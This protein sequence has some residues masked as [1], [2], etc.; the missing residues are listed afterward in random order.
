MITKRKQF[1]PPPAHMM[2]SEVVEYLKRQVFED[3]RAAGWLTPCVRKVGGRGKDT[4]FYAFTD[5]QD[6]S[7]R[8]AAGEYPQEEP[9]KLKLEQRTTERA[10]S[11]PHAGRAKAA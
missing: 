1:F 2:Q 10:S 4:I 6:V 5:V 8:I 11:P 9:D 7:L 3:A